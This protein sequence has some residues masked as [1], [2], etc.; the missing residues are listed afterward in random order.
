[1]REIE[2]L[3]DGIAVITLERL[4]LDPADLVSGVEKIGSLNRR[5]VNLDRLSHPSFDERFKFIR[6]MTELV[7]ARNMAAPAL[8]SEM[9]R[10]EIARSRAAVLVLQARLFSADL[11]PG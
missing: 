5:I 7:K 2:L 9:L 4:G 11:W 6:A 3:C 1:M 10:V 8:C